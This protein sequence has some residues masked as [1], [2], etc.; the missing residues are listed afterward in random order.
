MIGLKVSEVARDHVLYHNIIEYTECQAQKADEYLAL[1]ELV[2]REHLNVL[3]A[4]S[5]AHYE[6]LSV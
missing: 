1:F 2:P 5:K 6:F 3:P 4:Q